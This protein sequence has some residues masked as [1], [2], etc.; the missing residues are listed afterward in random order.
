MELTLDIKVMKIWN[1]VYFI[2]NTKYKQS[3]LK[4]KKKKKRKK[5]IGSQGF[6]IIFEKTPRSTVPEHNRLRK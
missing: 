3:L 2:I 5:E 6:G 1:K 4:C